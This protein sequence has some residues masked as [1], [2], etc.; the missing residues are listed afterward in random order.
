VSNRAST[1]ASPSWPP[2]NSPYDVPV[3]GGELDVDEVLRLLRAGR[4]DLAVIEAACSRQ[5]QGIASTFKYGMICEA[6]GMAPQPAGIA[7]PS[8]FAAHP[9]PRPHRALRPATSGAPTV[10]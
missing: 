3:A 1:A 2:T 9:G 4:V 10:Q 7:N 8:A 5:G 6:A